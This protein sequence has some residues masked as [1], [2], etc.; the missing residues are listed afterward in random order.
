MLQVPGWRLVKDKAG[1][2]CIQQEWK[3][4]NFVSSIEFFRRVGTIAEDEGHH[5]DLHLEDWNRVWIQLS[6]HSAGMY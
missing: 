5:P 1:H 3:F 4:L 2:P 6:T